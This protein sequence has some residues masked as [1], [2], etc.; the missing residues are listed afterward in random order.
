MSSAADTEDEEQKDRRDNRGNHLMVPS[1]AV[2]PRLGSL[3]GRFS[4]SLGVV[5][6]VSL[7]SLVSMSC[8]AFALSAGLHQNHHPPSEPLPI[9]QKLKLNPQT[10]T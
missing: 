6:L 1:R 9:R 8:L 7:V 10:R 3:S 5:I 4:S 2:D